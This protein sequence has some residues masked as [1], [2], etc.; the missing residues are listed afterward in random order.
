M[1]ENLYSR[2]LVQT[3]TNLKVVPKLMHAKTYEQ[4]KRAANFI[5]ITIYSFAE[6]LPF[7]NST[8]VLEFLNAY[9]NSMKMHAYR[10]ICRRS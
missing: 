2:H 7:V 6:M 1:K 8:V 9:Q 10:T 3:F 4:R 5:E